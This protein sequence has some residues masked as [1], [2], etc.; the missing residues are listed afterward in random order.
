M[1]REIQDAY[2]ILKDPKERQ[3]YDDHREQILKGGTPGSENNEDDE[4]YTVDLFAYHSVSAYTNYNDEQD[5]FFTV[6]RKLF[7][8][9]DRDEESNEDDDVSDMAPDFGN[10]NSK[11][12]HVERFYQTW[13]SFCSKRSFGW[14]DK[15]NPSE[16]PDRRTRRYVEKENKTLRKSMEQGLNH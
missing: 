12:D 13:Q 11:W 3:W 1:F 5:G 15:Y 4:S 14:C 2:E 16:A 9:L 8:R 10:S 6:Y 7:A